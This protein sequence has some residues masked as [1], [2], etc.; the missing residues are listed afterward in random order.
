MKLSLKACRINVGASAADI[1]A[2][3]GVSVKTIYSWENGKTS[4]T[5]TQIPKILNFFKS[6]NFEIE[7]D[8][9][10]FLPK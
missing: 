2:A 7:M 10:K 4:P 8:N 6:K 9:I 3:V 5:I 1:A